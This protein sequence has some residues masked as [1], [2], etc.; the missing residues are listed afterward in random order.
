MGYSTPEGFKPL[1]LPSSGFIDSNGPIYGK[2]DRGQVVI[3]IRIEERHCNSAGTCHGGMLTTLADMLLA[4]GS[5][6]Q[7]DLSRF[8]PTISLTC[9]FLGQAPLGAWVEG[10][11]QVLRVARSHVFSH[12]VLTIDE[13]PILRASAVLKLPSEPDPRYAASRFL[14]E[15]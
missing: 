8:L 2:R 6:L 11:P 12:G 13:E 5:N 3:G 15:G 1:P 4:M 7:A 9:D 10:R 14:D